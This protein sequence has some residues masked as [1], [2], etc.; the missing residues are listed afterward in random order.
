MP[1][2]EDRRHFLSWERPLLPQAVAFLAKD[3]AGKG[4]LDLSRLLVIVPTRQAGR[5]LR[6]ALAEYAKRHGQGVFAPRVMTPEVMLAANL[7]EDVASRPDSLLAWSWVLQNLP[8][9]EFREVFPIDPPVRDFGWALR[10]ARE[11]CVLQVALAENGLLIAGV[12]AKIGDGLP[13][14]LRWQQLAKLE[15]LHARL[16]N[17]AG[18]LDGPSARIS[19]APQ[20]W[21]TGIER[22]VLLATPDPLPL[23]LSALQAHE[24]SIET[25]VVVFAPKEERHAFDEWGRPIPD[26]WKDRLLKVDPFES[27]VHLCSDPVEQ[28]ERLAEVAREYAEPEGLVA[29]GL[30]DPEIVPP[31]ESA[32]ARHR[33]ASF[34]PEGI[35][36]KKAGLYQLLSSL[37]ALMREP[38]YPHVEALARCPDFIFYLRSKSEGS[39]SVADWLAG[40]DQL[41]AKH[42]P[43]D[44]SAALRQAKKP[45]N[46]IEVLN[47]LKAMDAFCERLSQG[48]FEESVT[49][50]LNELF[51]DRKIDLKSDDDQRFEN[52]ALAWME[53][54][55]GCVRARERFGD[56]PMKDWWDLALQLFAESIQTED[57]VEGALELQGWLELA[58]ENAP[59]LLVG[60]L[61]DGRVP[62]AVVGDAFLPE[63]LRIRLG[64]A[65]NLTRF[66]RD[67]YLLQAMASSR[68]A[69]GRLDLFFGKT[70]LTGEPLR[71]SRLLLRC[72]DEELPSRVS[73]L[74]GTPEKNEQPIAW[75][76]AWQ[77]RPRRENP[78]ARVAVTGLRA[79]LACPFR[80]YLSYVLKMKP[81]DPAKNEL[82][83]FDFGTLC[84]AALEG[85]AGVAMRDCADE[86][87]LRDFLLTEFDRQVRD[88]YGVELSLPL[89]VQLESARQRLSKVA[90]VQ[91]IERAEG[92]VIVAVEKKIEIE[93]DGIVISG[94][95]DRIE[96][97]ERTGQVRVLDYK[98]SDTAVSPFDAH[99]RSLRSD[100]NP[101]AWARIQVEGRER[102]W[103]DLQ[104]PLYRH[105]LAAEFGANVTFAYFNL[106]KAAGETGL[107]PWEDFSIELQESA[108]QCA[109]GICAAIKAGEFWPPNER[110]KADYDDFATL[111][112][113]GVAASVAW[114]EAP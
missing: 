111:F 19:Q 87:T 25:D 16:L 22:I 51:G 20:P 74:F 108:M 71:P 64:L 109:R 98:T 42:L 62:E 24:D 47:G 105:A 90:E 58:W 81:V 73:Y 96:K 80:F 61:N 23:A 79:W 45:G 69:G 93:C 76:R 66:A 14:Q 63:S 57:K 33:I 100:G 95:I 41:R 38:V 68:Q 5:R 26:R 32:L 13:E 10:L 99:L 114:E 52:A 27:H 101:P 17:R 44:L 39:F 70:S 40:L 50:A 65:T 75:T 34:S 30:A 37:A 46:R 88:R 94:R 77:L 11:F 2:A 53:C 4:P 28:A 9:E 60:G 55:R 82:D 106:P 97:N 104:L 102:V 112:Q 78:P 35:P 67:A 7:S 103:A 21:L 91:S 1:P 6:E 8:I 15:T 54:V 85:L 59:H 29:F 49:A 83:A 12:A 3:W 89:L 113:H 92:W 31:L 110:I 72:A 36:R 48:A 56:M 18:L 43:G 107:R 84:H 86:R